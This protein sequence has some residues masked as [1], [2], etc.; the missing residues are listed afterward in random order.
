MDMAKPSLPHCIQLEDLIK[1][2]VGD[3]IIKMLIDCK[4]FYDYDQ[5]ETGGIS[6]EEFD[7]L[8]IGGY[9]SFPC[10]PP[11]VRPSSAKSTNA[12]STGAKKEEEKSDTKPK[13]GES[14][15]EQPKSSM[16]SLDD[17][18]SLQL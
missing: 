4:G 10:P 5:R 9:N 12:S 16:T 6:E 15:K 8:D 3:I 2:G 13:D 11:K 18:P 17:L 7:E 1:S 14:E